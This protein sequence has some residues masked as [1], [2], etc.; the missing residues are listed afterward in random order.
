MELSGAIAIVTGAGSGI[1]RAIAVAL[2]EGGAASVAV[3]DIDET[4]AQETARQVRGA[5][6]RSTAH[7]VDVSD[8]VSLA[9]LFADVSHEEGPISVVCNNAGIVSGEPGW[10]GSSLAR[11]SAVIDVNLKG[12]VFGTRLA[13]EE[14]S[15]RGGVVV[16]TASV[17]GIVPLPEDAVYAATKAAVVH[18]TKSCAPLAASHGVRV[19]V[20]CPGMVDTPILAKTGTGSREAAWV[21]SARESV[22][23]LRPE[24][25]ADG[26]LAVI[27]DDT[28]AGEVV[29]LANA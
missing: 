9:K 5:G 8:A 24:A 18:F 13:I 29:I 28:K 12:V 7:F 15:G 19:N 21:T 4:A 6:A 11:L 16:N 14:M 25:I 2:A 17:A 3:V 10:P 1:G 20:V 23:L 27:H 22:E 26:V